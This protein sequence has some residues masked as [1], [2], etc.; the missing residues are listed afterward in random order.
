[1]DG[2]ALLLKD[3]DKKPAF[4]E[5]MAGVVSLTDKDGGRRSAVYAGEAP[6]YGKETFLERLELELARAE[7]LFPDAAVQGIADGAAH[8]WAWLTPRTDV[9]V[10]DF[11][12]MSTYVCKASDILFPKKISDRDEWT[13]TWLHKIKYSNNGADLLIEELE[14]RRQVLK[15]PSAEELK[16]VLVY[17]RNQKDRTHYRRERANNRPIG[18]GVTEAACKTLIKQ[19]MC[20]SGM[21]WSKDGA[22]NIIGIRSLILSNNRWSQFW[23]H[24][25][26]RGGI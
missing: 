10:L 14:E 12:H 1:L 26:T 24:Y 9:Q 13:E 3:K 22:S 15:K 6:E 20:C 11:Y 19:R 2:T 23:N 17:L 25:M 18:S 8:N 16:K 7:S 5:A 4:R 21:R